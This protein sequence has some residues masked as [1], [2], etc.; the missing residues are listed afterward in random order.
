MEELVPGGSKEA[1]PDWSPDG[2]RIVFG[3]LFSVEDATR[4][5][6][7]VVDLASKQVSILPNSQHLFHPSWSPDGHYIVAI[8][9]EPSIC[10]CMTFGR[11]NGAN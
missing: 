6:I 10:F 9:S 3:R 4:V 11:A 8:H 2:K 1:T 5:A 7:N